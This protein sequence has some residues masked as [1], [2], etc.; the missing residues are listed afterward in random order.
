M[1]GDAQTTFAA[2]AHALIVSAGVPLVS[3]QYR[4]VPPAEVPFPHA[5]EAF[6][7][8]GRSLPE[9]ENPI[10]DLP[11]PWTLVSCAHVPADGIYAAQQ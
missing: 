5:S 11:H 2:T 10:D 9:H 1:A 3:Q 4:V 6:T 8:S 7:W